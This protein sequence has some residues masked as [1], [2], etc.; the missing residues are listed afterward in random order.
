MVITLQRFGTIYKNLAG[1]KLLLLRQNNLVV[2]NDSLISPVGNESGSVHVFA[3]AWTGLARTGVPAAN[4]SGWTSSSNSESGT[5]GFVLETTPSW[6]CIQLEVCSG[7][8]FRLMCVQ[9]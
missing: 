4:C 7:S 9:Q 2:V 5:V 1:K 3:A 8:S 6:S